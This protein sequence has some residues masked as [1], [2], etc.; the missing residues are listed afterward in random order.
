M[1][2]MNLITEYNDIFMRFKDGKISQRELWQQIQDFHA[3][4]SPSRCEA[5]QDNRKSLFYPCVM[6]RGCGANAPDCYCGNRRSSSYP[7]VP[8][9]P[10]TSEGERREAVVRF[11]AM[12]KDSCLAYMLPVLK[13]A[14]VLSSDL[15]DFYK[16]KSAIYLLHTI[17]QKRKK[18]VEERSKEAQKKLDIERKLK[19][20]NE[21]RLRIQDL[22]R[23]L[24]SEKKRLHN[25]RDGGM[26][27]LLK[28]EIT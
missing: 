10:Q 12:Y 8:S 7:P 23:Q 27:E 11:H 19:L 5:F 6:C 17:E 21:V 14:G 26:D 25:M 13:R 15:E 16:E 22:E 24:E 28:G 4:V 1:S 18:E 2:K 3:K 20:E 9:S